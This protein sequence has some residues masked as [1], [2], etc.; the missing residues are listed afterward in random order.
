M[1]VYHLVPEPMQ[2]KNIHVPIQNSKVLLKTLCGREIIPPFYSWDTDLRYN[3]LYPEKPFKCDWINRVRYRTSP[4][5]IYNGK[6]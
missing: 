6:F 2:M 3:D 1:I 4:E 5:R